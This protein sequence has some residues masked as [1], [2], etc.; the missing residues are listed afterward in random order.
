M[1]GVVVGSILFVQC[2]L[3]VFPFV[4]PFGV[5]VVSVVRSILFGMLLVHCCTFGTS[6]CNI[7]WLFGLG[8]FGVNVVS[9]R[10]RLHLLQRRLSEVRSLNS[11]ATSLE[12]S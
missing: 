10:M 8:F 3:S 7:I 1:D 6:L 5:N 11:V 12:H 2:T 9:V 4:I